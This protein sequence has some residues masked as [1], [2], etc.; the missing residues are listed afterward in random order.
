MSKAYSSI[1]SAMRSQVWAIDPNKLEAIMAFLALKAQGKDAEAS[2]VAD[3]H[4]AAQIQAARAKKVQQADSQATSIAV[5]PV[6]GLILHRGSSMRDISGPAATSTVRLLQQFNAAMD[7][8]SVSAIIFDI[9]SPGGTVEGVDELA[10]AIRNAKGKKQ[11]I[12][13][14][15][16]LCASA[17]YFIASACSEIVASPSSMTGS[18]GVYCAHE[19]TSKYLENLGV[20]VS[21]IKFGE[22]KAE[23]NPHEP[24]TDA[25]RA[26]MQETVDM[27][28]N[29]FE[30]AVAK[31]RSVPQQKVH[32]TFGQGLMF[33]AAQAVKIG[34]VDKVDTFDAVLARFG[35]SLSSS[36]QT[37]MELEAPPVVGSTSAPK[38]DVGCKCQCAACLGGDCGSCTDDDCDDPNCEGCAMQ[39][40]AA[41]AASDRMR[42]RLQIANAEL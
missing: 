5:L 13:V 34:M 19:D 28:G 31:G 25:A 14:C 27:F 42:F 17:A 11:T 40:K 33:G 12:A 15:N 35:V 36:N 16:K 26:H 4:G 10:T 32:D 37:S 3:L 39:A 22:N 24:L 6:Y 30:K 1:M 29:M 20:K 9:D 38:A 41:K 23:G 21:L 2:V 7:D 18:I 8:P